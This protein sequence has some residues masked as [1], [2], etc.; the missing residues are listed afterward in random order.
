MPIS[1]SHRVRNTSGFLSDSKGANYIELCY[2]WYQK[3]GIN[4]QILRQY[5]S[6]ADVNELWI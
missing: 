5:N 6:D 4:K 1:I 3:A 2:I